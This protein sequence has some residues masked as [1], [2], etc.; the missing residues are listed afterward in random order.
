[1]PYGL[2]NIRLGLGFY[3]FFVAGPYIDRNKFEVSL[4]GLGFY[5]F[6]GFLLSLL[7]FL[8]QNKLFRAFGGIE[9]HN[10]FMMYFYDF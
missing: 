8:S 2:L 5:L 4:Y 9:C 1:M 6:F 3:L 10:E 7:I